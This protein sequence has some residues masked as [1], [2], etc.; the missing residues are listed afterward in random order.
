[1]MLVIKIPYGYKSLTPKQYI[2]I[3]SSIRRDIRKNSGVLVKQANRNPGNN[4][5]STAQNR[6]KFGLDISKLDGVISFDPDRMTIDVG[7]GTTFFDITRLTIP[8]GLI[9]PVV[10]G[11]STITVGGA[12][13]GIGCES[14]SFRYGFVHDNIIE[15]DV[16]LSDGN[17]L[18]ITPVSH[19]N[20][21]NS[22]PNS[23]GSIAYIT[24]V[25]LSLIRSKSYV[26]IESKKVSRQ[27]FFDQ[28]KESTAKSS[29]D[30]VEGFVFDSN[31]CT[32]VEASFTNDSR[33]C[34]RIPE[35]VI[36]T[37]SIDFIKTL[38][39]FDY[40]WR[41][42]T[43]PFWSLNDYPIFFNPLVCKIFG[44]KLLNH[45]TTRSLGLLVD[46]IKKKLGCQTNKNNNIIQDIGIPIENCENFVDWQLE[47]IGVCPLWICPVRNLTNTSCFGIHMNQLYCD[48][49]IFGN[50]QEEANE[51]KLVH[52]IEQKMFELGGNKCFYSNNYFSQKDLE[53]SINYQE[54]AQIKVT[55]DPNGYFKTLESKACLRLN[56]TE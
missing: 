24:K 13:S 44:R 42:D 2:R 40:I 49:G 6:A 32:V 56:N 5:S 34:L 31:N 9:P 33:D 54:Y 45:Y 35:D 19:R 17:L 46:Q 52:E 36:Y 7:S 48:I 37:E 14:S 55:Y 1:M 28:I 53:S 39:T 51:P 12:I 11:F 38:K 20:L 10:P 41:H 43:H 8:H 22:L 30:F 16:L 4:Y 3:I 27:N 26:R 18:T 47:K 50:P 29:V 21:W 25:K 15:M 23:F